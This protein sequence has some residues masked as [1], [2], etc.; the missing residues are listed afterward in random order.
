MFV[1]FERRRFV[2]YEKSNDQP[3][4]HFLAGSKQ[5]SQSEVV[6]V[7]HPDFLVE[8]TMADG[9]RLFSENEIHSWKRLANQWYNLRKETKERIQKYGDELE[10][11]PNSVI[12]SIKHRS[13]ESRNSGWQGKTKGGAQAVITWKWL[14]EDIKPVITTWFE[15]NIEKA[16]FEEDFTHDTWLKLPEGKRAK[17]AKTSAPEEPQGT[18]LQLHQSDEYETCVYI[19]LANT[20]FLLG[21]F[22]AF[23]R[24]KTA[25]ENVTTGKG[26]ELVSNISEQTMNQGKQLLRVLKYD[27]K[28]VKIPDIFVFDC[29]W[30]VMC[31]ITAMHCVV[32]WRGVIIDSSARTTLT[33]TKKNLDWCCGGDGEFIGIIDA[34][35]FQSTRKKII[36][37]VENM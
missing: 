19:N 7:L 15:E 28:I 10:R 32:V 16:N 36:E 23:E 29:N 1:S 13:G 4:N 27:I 17:R 31:K 34:F 25:L 2:I 6:E 35:M 5:P 8:S 21:D 26:K 3:E 18:S 30:P 20:L 11:S 33:L 22:H 37:K 9:S 24:M 12:I 14:N